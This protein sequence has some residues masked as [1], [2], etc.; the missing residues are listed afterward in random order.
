MAAITRNSA[1][2]SVTLPSDREIT[3][4]RVFD[5]PRKL[6][7]EAWTRPEHV[8]L[9]YGCRGSSLVLCE[10]DFRLGGAYRFVTRVADGN[11]Y[12]MSGVYREIVP[13]ER[14]V[15]TERFNDDPGKEALITL[16]LEERDGRTTLTSVARYRTAED[17]DAVLEFGVEK[18]AR[19][20][21][22]R[23]AEHLATMSH[24]GRI[25]ETEVRQ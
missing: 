15:Y 8:K 4:S 5:A 11:V 24:R 7:F 13:P 22:D 23:L 3:L 16:T 21:F 12:P 17:R 19:E 14:L 2:F 18:G 20:G 9:W 25:T 6:V 1:A 10:I